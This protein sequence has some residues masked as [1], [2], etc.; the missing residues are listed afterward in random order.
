MPLTKVCVSTFVNVMKPVC[1]CGHTFAKSNVTRQSKR[2]AMKRKRAVESEL[3]TAARQRK[4][5]D[6]K[7]WQWNHIEHIAIYRHSANQYTIRRGFC[8]S[9]L[10]ICIVVKKAAGGFFLFFL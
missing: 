7:A 2:I 5:R 10:L 8:T 4:D 9:V 6:R 1:V 3:E